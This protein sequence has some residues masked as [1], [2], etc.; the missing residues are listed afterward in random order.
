MKKTCL[1]FVTA[2]LLNSCLW[3]KTE[4]KEIHGEPRIFTHPETGME[5][6][7]EVPGGSVFAYNM[8]DFCENLDYE[9]GGWRW[10]NIDDLRELVT[11]CPNVMPKG[12]CRVTDENHDW[13]YFDNSECGCYE[14]ESVKNDDDIQNTVSLLHDKDAEKMACTVMKSSSAKVYYSDIEKRE[15]YHIGFCEDGTSIY[16]GSA[17]KLTDP[18]CARDSK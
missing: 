13:E 7:Y 3:E 15:F 14:E 9:G 5:Y 17:K 6:Y 1:F 10:A 18:I 4:D 8:K 16:V 12:K 2:L 11:N